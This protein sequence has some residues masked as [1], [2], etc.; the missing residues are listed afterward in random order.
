MLK[1]KEAYIN[2]NEKRR[3]YDKLPSV[4]SVDAVVVVVV[5]VAVVVENVVVVVATTFVQ[6]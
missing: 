4:N 1:E 5:T 3:L 6:L 2:D